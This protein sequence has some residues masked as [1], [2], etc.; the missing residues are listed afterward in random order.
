M[1]TDGIV[2]GEDLMADPRW[3]YVQ[4]TPIARLRLD[5]RNLPDQ[6]VRPDGT[7]V[8]LACNTP[9]RG[10]KLLCETHTK[11]SARLTKARARLEASTVVPISKEAINTILEAV[12]GLTPLM[13]QLTRAYNDPKADLR[14]ET[15]TLMRAVKS[16]QSKVIDLLPDTRPARRAR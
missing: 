11:E 14:D 2:T 6:R 5:A 12:H 10:K 15:D 9:V 4:H 16:M 7:P 8:C 3:P 1:S 13:G